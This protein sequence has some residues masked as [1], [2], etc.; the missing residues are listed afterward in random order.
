MLVST[1]QDLEN[2]ELLDSGLA[3]RVGLPKPVPILVAPLLLNIKKNNI[4][5]HHFLFYFIF[6]AKSRLHCT[7]SLNYI[8]K[9]M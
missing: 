2:R 3:P 9:K 8:K 7:F 5:V 6:Y 1:L 4:K